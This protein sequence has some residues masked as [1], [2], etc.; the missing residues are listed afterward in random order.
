MTWHKT[1]YTEYNREGKE[2]LP[3]FDCLKESYTGE[4]TIY[5]VKW[6]SLV[7]CK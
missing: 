2:Q 1:V 3:R 7:S 5:L 6:H 4:P